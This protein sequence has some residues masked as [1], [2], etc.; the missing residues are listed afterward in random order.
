LT[1]TITVRGAGGEPK[2][3]TLTCGDGS[4]HADG[5][6]AGARDPEA[7]CRH[8][9]ELAPFLTAAPDPHR[10]CAQVY[11]GPETA[12]VHGRIGDQRVDRRFARTD[13]CKI[14]DWDRVAVLFEGALK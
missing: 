1:L 9:R 7:L 2:H 14:A 10:I 8:A 11:G 13:S 4:R 3:A 6:L 12:R 5:F